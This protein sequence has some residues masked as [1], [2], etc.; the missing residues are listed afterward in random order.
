MRLTTRGRLLVVVSLGAFVMATLFA[1]RGL[2]AIVLPGVIALSAAYLQL[3]RMTAPTPIRETPPDDF[4]GKDHEVTIRFVDRD[5]GQATDG[6]SRPFVGVIHETVGDGLSIVQSTHE[7][8]VGAEPVT[9]E[10]NYEARGEHTFGPAT[11]TARDVLGVA[12]T[13]LSCPE[14]DGVTVYPRVRTIA[15]WA[16]R[17][18]RALHETGLHEERSE[19]DRLREYDRGDSL[20]DIHWKSTAKRDDLI[21]KE[22]AAEAETEGVRIAAGATAGNADGMASATT[23]IALALIEDG[24]PVDVRLPDGDVQAGPERSSRVRLLERLATVGAGRVRDEDADVEIRGVDGKT[25]VRI[26]ENETTFTELTEPIPPVWANEP[27]G[28]QTGTDTESDGEEA[29]V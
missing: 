11:I 5:T 9:Y 23:S 10:V 2:N 3:R 22:F 15:G 29:V 20:R 16:R 1:P 19:F 8:V 13:E 17:D 7:T 12:E 4:A 6:L 24:I 18:L 14:T 27:P 26:G 28:G 25:T 21:V